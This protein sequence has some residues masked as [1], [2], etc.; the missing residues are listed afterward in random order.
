MSK[1]MPEIKETLVKNW[2]NTWSKNESKIFVK[3]LA[4]ILK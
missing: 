3:N 4:K 2:N 1:E